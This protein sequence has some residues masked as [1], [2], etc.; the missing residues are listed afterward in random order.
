MLEIRLDRA[1]HTPPYRQVVAQV[2]EA[3]RMGWLRPGDQLPAVREVAGGSGINPNTVLK[4]Y[5]ELAV[6]G[7]TE[8][9]PGSGTFVRDTLPAADPRLMVK[10]RALLEKWAGNA[11]DAGLGTDDLRTLVTSVLAEQRLGRASGAGA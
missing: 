10:Y 1:S 8:T 11:R 6:L 2:R 4:A 9:R 3:L 5:H 7:V